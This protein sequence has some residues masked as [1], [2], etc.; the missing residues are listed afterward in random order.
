MKD[1]K[2]IELDVDLIGKEIPLSKED[3]LRISDFIKKNN[4]KKRI[5]RK[6]KKV[7]S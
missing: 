6:R 3:E 1:K 2:D 7:V 4:S 5:T